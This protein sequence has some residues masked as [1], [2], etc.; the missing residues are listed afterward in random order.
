M[1]REE[2]CCIGDGWS[3]SAS[4]LTINTVLC[5]HFIFLYLKD[6]QFFYIR[7]INGEQMLITL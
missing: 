5:G 4:L 3:L 7:E 2:P 1:G 6:G